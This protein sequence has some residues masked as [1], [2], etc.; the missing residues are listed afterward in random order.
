MGTVA[1]MSP[2]QAQGRPVDTRSDIFSFG[3]VLYEMLSGRRAFARDSPFETITAIVQEEPIP[4]QAPPTLAP[5]SEPDRGA[6]APVQNAVC[7]LRRDMSGSALPNTC[8][9]KIS[10]HAII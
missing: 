8:R 5:S 1:Y 4:L 3:L 6:Y 10:F 9:L 2:E 7:C